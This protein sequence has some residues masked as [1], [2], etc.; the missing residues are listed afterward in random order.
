MAR[1]VARTSFSSTP[2]ARSARS[3]L[4]ARMHPRPA[5]G[6]ESCLA[7]LHAFPCFVRTCRLCVP[8]LSPL[9]A[10]RVSDTWGFRKP[11]VPYLR[12][13]GEGSHY[14]GSWCVCLFLI[15]YT[16]IYMHMQ[17]VD[18]HM[19]MLMSMSMYVYMF[20]YMYVYMYVYTYMCMHIVCLR[21]S[22]CHTVHSRTPNVPA[23]LSG[24]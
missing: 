17:H 13:H 1:A 7:S 5:E 9:V 4:I 23:S 2:P 16:Y 19:S 6:A 10:W 22:S 14:L 11:G 12:Y 24:L 20:V 15:V 18:M 21:L 3:S 8:A